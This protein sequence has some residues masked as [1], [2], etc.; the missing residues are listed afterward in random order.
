MN[1][2]N[3]LIVPGSLAL[4]RELAPRDDTARD[5][6]A[7]IG[8]LVAQDVR[9]IHI[10]GSQDQ[11]WLTAHTG[12]FA[13]WGAPQVTVGGGNYAAELVARYCLGAAEARV[14]E[15]R[16]H[17]APFDPAVLTVVVLDGSA[18]LTQRAPLALIDGAQTAHQQ[19]GDFL[20]GQAM[21]PEDLAAAGVV[22]PVLWHELAALR[23]RHAHLIAAD[24][25]LG[26]GRFIATWQVDDEQVDD[27]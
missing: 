2:F 5:F 3:V 22:E 27:E 6:R 1:Q 11:R 15:S 19:M 14:T 4:V 9:P 26:V 24:D 13:A 18:G 10:V 17:I 21:L 20:A 12:S 23:P 25:T 16:A 7:T 8:T